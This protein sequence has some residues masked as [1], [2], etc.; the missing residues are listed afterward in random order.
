MSEKHQKAI[1]GRRPRLRQLRTFQN[2]QGESLKTE[3]IGSVE[4]VQLRLKSRA[5]L[6]CGID[7][8]I[9]VHRLGRQ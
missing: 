1:F 6:H 7:P 3:A 2:D 9:E 4:S 8:E 5:A